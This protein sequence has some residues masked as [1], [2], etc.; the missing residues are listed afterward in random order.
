MRMTFGLDEAL[1]I[2]FGNESTEETG[3][4]DDDAN[5]RAESDS[6]TSAGGNGT[7][8]TTRSAQHK[9]K[10]HTLPHTL[11][12]VYSQLSHPPEPCCGGAYAQEQMI[13]DSWVEE[14]RQLER[15]NERV[16]V[17]H[18]GL[19][20]WSKDIDEVVRMDEDGILH[21]PTT[22]WPYGPTVIDNEL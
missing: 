21:V 10:R 5:T 19:L 11:R 17:L 15:R 16:V 18:C 14:I 20:A 7:A 4:Q 9:Q 8:S 3:V 6:N 13:Y 12:W 2:G 1:G 22:S